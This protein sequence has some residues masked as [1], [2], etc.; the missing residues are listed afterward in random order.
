MA[1]ASVRKA[2][3]QG[4]VGARVEAKGK[5]D[6]TRNHLSL[7]T[8]PIRDAHVYRDDTHVPPAAIVSRGLH[9][10]GRHLP[11]WLLHIPSGPQPCGLAINSQL[12]RFIAVNELT[13]VGAQ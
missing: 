10:S 13:V 7:L 12:Q 9:W 11:E 4:V 8:H 2:C 6:V 5:V 3:L 1:G